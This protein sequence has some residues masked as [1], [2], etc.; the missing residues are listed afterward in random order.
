ML[1][2]DNPFLSWLG[3]RLTQ[4][5]SGYCE[6]RL[7]T[8]NHH[9]NRIGRVQG[10]VIATLLDAACGYSGLYVEP[11]EAP[12]RNVT[13]SLTTQFL[14]TGE[15]KELVARGY[16]ERRGRSVYFARGEVLLDSQLLLATA[17]GTFKYLR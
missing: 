17:V 1:P 14:D 2:I 6:M 4:W 13:L 8:T 15:G 11:G 10:G 3:V 9:M 12:L 5:S 16:V 7:D